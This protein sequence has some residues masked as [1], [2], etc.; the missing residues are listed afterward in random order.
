[1]LERLHDRP[2][3]WWPVLQEMRRD[4]DAPAPLDR[5]VHHAY[6]V[7]ECL[8]WD[9]IDHAIDKR[10]LVAERRKAFAERQT[11]PCD[12]HTCHACGAC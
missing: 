5:F 3:D 11:P 1:V 6:A 12:T 10:Y 2:G 7:D 4:A 8:P 9:V